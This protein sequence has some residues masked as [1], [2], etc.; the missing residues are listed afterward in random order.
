MPMDWMILGKIGKKMILILMCVKSMP[1][2]GSKC[3]GSP[4]CP[5][6]LNDKSGWTKRYLQIRFS[7]K[8]RISV[9]RIVSGRGARTMW[10]GSKGCWELP[11]GSPSTIYLGR[12][13]D[14]RVRHAPTRL[15]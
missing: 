4:F 13:I 11:N 8:S 10:T 1:E 15:V 14:K 9:E 12:P 3:Q 2:R 5:T 7:A 6:N